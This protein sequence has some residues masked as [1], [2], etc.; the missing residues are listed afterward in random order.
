MTADERMAL[1]TEAFAA[2][3]GHPPTLWTRAPGRVDLMG[4]HTDYNHG[5]IL[6]MTID[7]DTWFAARPRA[8]RTV[9]VASLDMGGESTFSL[10]AVNTDHD[11]RWANYVR[12]MASVM[13]EAGYT[14]AGVDALIHTT[15]PVS[16]G[17]SSSAALEMAAGRMFEAVAGLAI[18]PVQLAVL[19]QRA[20]NN[21]VGV[22]CGILDQY[23][24]AVG[25][26]GSALLLDARTITSQNVP[27]TPDIRVVIC[28][29][30]TKRELAGSEYGRRRAQ[31]E[32][33]A[34][35]LAA[36][37]PGIT[38]LRD[39]N[40][41]QFE[42]RA[43]ELEPEV[44]RRCRFI[45]EENARVAAFATALSA[46]DRSAMSD[47][48]AAS[49]AGA[50]DLYAITSCEMQVMLAAMLAAPGCIAAR[51]AGAGFG[52][53]MAAFVEA[54]SETAFAA[55]VAP[56]YQAATGIEPHIYPVVASAGA[57]RV[58]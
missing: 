47:L 30:R 49:F 20:E 44:A 58:E 12:G 46:G 40:L 26:A 11:Q 25:Q 21:F 5:F 51:Q 9:R 17:L 56:A 42:A 43:G 7:R 22:N 2:R 31:C 28:D 37:Y 32:E 19:G 36:F 50:R 16:A 15:V 3:Y 34:R 41:A 18:D 8:D 53:C 35:A 27:L 55:Q 48:C 29:T 13:Q 1:M 4:S 10:D 52:G 45:V 54:G 6:T 23:T 39:V 24:S 57:G 33:G 38:H 14:L